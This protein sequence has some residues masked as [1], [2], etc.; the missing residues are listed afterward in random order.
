MLPSKG[1]NRLNNVYRLWL[2][3]PENYIITLSMAT[4]S[5]VHSIHID[6]GK[7]AEI[8]HGL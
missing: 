5:R 8:P 7:A 3:L 6:Q 2:N 4:W 1:S